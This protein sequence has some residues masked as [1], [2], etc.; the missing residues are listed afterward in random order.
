VAQPDDLPDQRVALVGVE[1]APADSA[2]LSVVLVGAEQPIR[3]AHQVKRGLNATYH[4]E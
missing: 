1:L 2:D 3:L 4:Q